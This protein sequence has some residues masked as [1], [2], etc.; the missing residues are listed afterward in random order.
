MSDFSAIGLLMALGIVATFNW[1]F[2]ERS[3]R[4]LGNAIVTG[5]V[6]GVPIST[7]QRRLLFQRHW[8]LFAPGLVGYQIII[9]IGWMLMARNM[10][11]EEVRNFAYLC[12]F[13]GSIATV[14]AAYYVLFGYF[15]I[16]SA[17]REAEQG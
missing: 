6:S 10:G 16:R 5:I 11:T 9:V 15:D 3:V 13:F 4:D 2:F 7:R 8:T 1:L 14:G 17:L 12:G